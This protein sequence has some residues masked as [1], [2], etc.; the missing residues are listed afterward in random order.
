[1][2]NPAHACMQWLVLIQKFPVHLEVLVHPV[3]L[4]D[5]ERLPDQGLQPLLTAWIVR[6]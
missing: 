5:H 3:G 6:R 2:E 1:M 4:E